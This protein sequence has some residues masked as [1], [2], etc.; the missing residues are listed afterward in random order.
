MTVIRIVVL[1]VR[2]VFF[3]MVMTA[4]IVVI[5]LIILIIN[6]NM[7]IISNRGRINDMIHIRKREVRIMT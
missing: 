3:K 1:N 7:C 2:P 6:I 5:V 4:L